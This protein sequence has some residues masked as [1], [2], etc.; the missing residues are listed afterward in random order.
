MESIVKYIEFLTF[1]SAITWSISYGSRGRTQGCRQC[2]LGL[3]FLGWG[4]LRTSWSPRLARRFNTSNV[5]TVQVLPAHRREV[6]DHHG[7]SGRGHGQPEVSGLRGAYGND[8]ELAQGLLWNC[9]DNYKNCLGQIAAG[10]FKLQ[11]GWC[12]LKYYSPFVTQIAK[13]REQLFVSKQ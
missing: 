11:I 5:Q 10:M 2:M 12:L 3:Y 6:I 7:P 13:K 4:C 8:Q 9:Q 1:F